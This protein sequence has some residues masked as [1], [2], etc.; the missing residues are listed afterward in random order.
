MTSY[1]VDEDELEEGGKVKASADMAGPE[2]APVATPVA[3]PLL[4][5]WRFQALWFG[6]SLANLG[7]EA[8]D[9]AFPLLILTITG[10][11]GLAGLFGFVEVATSVLA[12][13]PAGAL[14]DRW[15]R[16]R[17]LLATDGLRA[18][19]IGAVVAGVASGHMAVG[20]L[21][22]AAVVL[23]AATA[24][25]APARM[26]ITRA[27]VPEEQLTAALSQEEARGGVAALAGPPVGGALFGVARAVPFLAAAVGFAVSFVC[28]F[29]AAPV[30]ASRPSAP[31]AGQNTPASGFSS[32]FGGFR[33]L[34]GNPMLRGAL[35]LISTFLLSATAAMLAVIVEL[36]HQHYSSAT[37]GLAVTGAA[38]G[39]LAGSVLVQHLHRRLR[40]GILVI[41]ASAQVTIAVALLALPFG[42]WWVAG[43]LFVG[44]LPLPA[45][46]VLVDVLIFRRTPDETRGR[47]IAATMTIVGIGAPIGSLIAG[48]TMQFATVTAA[49]L[50][51]AGIQAAV[52]ITGLLDRQV[53]NSRWPDKQ[54][55]A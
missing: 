33:F 21:L 34:L 17:V 39:M 46:R 43:M 52:T 22:A 5:N 12:T 53:R 37:I 40:P 54:A 11:P 36:R 29:L 25:G 35:A 8:T 6:G 50:A 38:C 41:G 44:A 49:V 31:D 48:V 47:A 30:R 7:V 14:V 15:D 27:V 24:L 23:G 4:R 32:A 20:F 9:I 45:L 16:R 19:T 28:V 10:A 1:H 26:L 3:V 18:L 55:E 51:V 13:L 42:P 2:S